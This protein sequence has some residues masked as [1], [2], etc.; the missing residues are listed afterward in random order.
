MLLLWAAMVFTE[1][2]THFKRLLL[3]TRDEKACA[4][5]FVY[6]LLPPPPLSLSLFPH[7]THTLS[8]SLLPP[9][10]LPPH[11]LYHMYTD[12]NVHTRTYMHTFTRACFCNRVALFG[13]ISPK[14][15]TL[16]G[17]PQCHGAA[18]PRGRFSNSPI[19]QLLETSYSLKNSKLE[20]SYSLKNKRGF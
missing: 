3:G 18:M 7:H 1:R 14:D 13:T 6:L 19:T 2:K 8:L 5:F 10:P 4:L 12:L 20:T 9:P 15:R 11:P 17:S 16:G